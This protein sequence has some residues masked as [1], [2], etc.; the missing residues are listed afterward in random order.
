MKATLNMK[1]ASWLAPKLVLTRRGLVDAASGVPA[2]V[3]DYQSSYGPL[4]QLLDALAKRGYAPCVEYMRDSQKW[5][6]TLWT[7]EPYKQ[8]ED[9]VLVNC[10]GQG[11]HETI[12]GCVA[13]AVGNL[14]D[15]E[16]QGGRQ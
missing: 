11:E 8:C 4:T 3:V 1:I 2:A 14:I 16:A 7:T 13:E 15:K 10:V 5:A 12:A 9:E 6:C